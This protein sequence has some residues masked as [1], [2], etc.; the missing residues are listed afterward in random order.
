MGEDLE[1]F[2]VNVKPVR[3]LVNLNSGFTDNYASALSSEVDATY[4]HTVRILHQLEDFGLVES[5]KEGR[6]KVI[7]LTSEGEEVAKKCGDLLG[8]LRDE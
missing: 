4:S 2:F 8:E 5:S 3:I 6:K 1:S 7:E